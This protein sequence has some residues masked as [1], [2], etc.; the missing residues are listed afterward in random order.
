MPPPRRG[1][2]N[3]GRVNIPKVSSDPHSL[4]GY[5]LIY[6]RLRQLAI[7]PTLRPSLKMRMKMTKSRMLK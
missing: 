4:C 5:L 2:G 6:Y 7:F 1:R 3:T